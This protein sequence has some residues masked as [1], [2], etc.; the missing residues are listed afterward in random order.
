MDKLLYK[1]GLKSENKEYNNNFVIST[2]HCL[3]NINALT[4]FI[5]DLDQN[6][7]EKDPLLD[8]YKKFLEILK[9]DDEKPSSIKQFEDILFEKD[10]FKKKENYNPQFLLN[11]LIT[12][13]NLFI[14]SEFKNTKISDI[15]AITIQTIKKCPNC[16]N[17]IEKEKNDE[18]K[19]LK[20]N[21]TQYT[22][23]GEGVE[24]NIYD[25]LRS[26]VKREDCENK[27]Y[28]KFCKKDISPHIKRIFKTLPKILII[29][30]NY[31]NDINFKL[32]KP[33]DF[34]E[35]ID[36]NKIEEVEENYKNKQ[37]E[38]AAL[39]SV[40][41]MMK[42]NEYFYSFCKSFCKDNDEDGK[43]FCYNADI[44]H[45]VKNIEN[46]INKQSIEIDNKKER[47][48]YILIYTIETK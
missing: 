20:Y 42:K 4:D 2:L 48:P 43:Y 46:K 28:C 17:F 26:Y 24:Y 31:G 41:D 10:D 11:Y 1:N 9:E 34:N 33:I 37:Y 18:K 23:N 12:D 45:K 47:F 8:E 35:K 39:V 16:K 5:K 40:K 25:C 36:F 38:L 29:F 30:V 22:N 6:E 3:I 19:N 7:C 21:I 13:F 44:V 14:S 15:F 32:N 27:G